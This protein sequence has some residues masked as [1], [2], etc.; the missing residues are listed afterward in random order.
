[1][2]ILVQVH[3]YKFRWKGRVCW[4]GVVGRAASPGGRSLGESAGR[5][6]ENTSPPP[7]SSLLREC[8]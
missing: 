7:A 2:K 3:L 4:L 6:K 8:T 5:A 1:M